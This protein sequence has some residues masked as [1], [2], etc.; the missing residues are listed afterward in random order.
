MPGHCVIKGNEDADRLARMDSDSYFYGQEPCVPQSAWIVRDIHKKWVIDAH[1]KNWIAPNSCRQSQLWIRVFYH[2]EL[3]AY[4]TSPQDGTNNKPCLCILPIVRETAALH[5][6]C[7]CPTL[8]T[9][10]TRVFGKPKPIMNASKFV[11]ALASAILRFAFQSKQPLTELTSIC[12]S[13]F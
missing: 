7:V 13:N 2:G 4:W 12:T 3:L 1:S 5:F 8:A 11:D 10:R 9:L 6:V